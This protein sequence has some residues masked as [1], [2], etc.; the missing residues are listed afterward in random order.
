MTNLNLGVIGKCSLAML[1]DDA[2]RIVW[3]GFPRLDREPIF[4]ALL[5]GT[6]PYRP[7]DRNSGG[8]FAIELANQTRSEPG[9]LPISRRASFNMGACF[10]RRRSCAEFLPSLFCGRTDQL[11]HA[12][13]PDMG[14]CVLSRARRCGTA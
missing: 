3:G 12:A 6:D 1:V 7:D 9:Y 10:A 2:A 13:E 14:R 11:R 5:G 8:Y 4:C